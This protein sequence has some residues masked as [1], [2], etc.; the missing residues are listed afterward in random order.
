MLIDD[1]FIVAYSS[2]VSSDVNGW[3]G[4]IGGRRE[5]SRATWK[6][7]ADGDDARTCTGN[8][9]GAMLTWVGEDGGVSGCGVW[10]YA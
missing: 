9:W 2:S 1:G 7:A 8:R 6:A 5:D 10:W 4:G 3:I